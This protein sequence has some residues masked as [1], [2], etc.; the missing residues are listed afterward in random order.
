MSSLT[1]FTAS[2][3]LDTL[4]VSATIGGANYGEGTFDLSGVSALQ[5][6]AAGTVVEFRMYAHTTSGQ[7]T[8]M[9]VGEAWGPDRDDMTLNGTV[10]PEP[11][12]LTLLVFVSGGMLWFR[13]R[14]AM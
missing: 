6:V 14:F 11:A 2:D 7:M 4:D 9:G 12:T 13:K 3:G 8:R 1:G 10:I 5:T